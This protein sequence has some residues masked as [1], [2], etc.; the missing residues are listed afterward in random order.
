M[1]RGSIPPLLRS[2]LGDSLKTVIYIHIPKCAGSTAL[3]LLHPL[4]AEG[5][6]Y[7]Q[8]GN[9]VKEKQ[10]L[11]D[12]DTVSKA[13]L[14]L[15]CGHMC[16]GWHEVMPANQWCT[17]VTL[18]RDPVD[19]VLSFCK[20][21]ERFKWHNMYA[22]M[23]DLDRDWG[24]F[25]S[26]GH[27]RAVNNGMVRILCGDDELMQ[28]HPDGDMRIPFGEVTKEHLAKAKANLET[29]S[30]VGISEEF[31]EFLH[32]LRATFGW[33]IPLHYKDLNSQGRLRRIDYPIELNKTIEEYNQLDRE[34]YDW[35]LEKRGHDNETPAFR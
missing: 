16:Y 35:I 34:L 19:R 6:V 29:F 21:V 11:R 27:C 22:T 14:K 7:R 10:A 24:V 30:V 25:V 8:T 26:S 3:G 33:K 15:V 2:L 18:L 20:Y 5:E 9:V 1:S 13:R 12:M 4:F 31:D 28:N 32:L 23:H 17:Y